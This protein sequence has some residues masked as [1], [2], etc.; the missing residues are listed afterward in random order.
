M[1][2]EER[3]MIESL[4]TRLHEAGT[5]I[6]KDQEAAALIEEKISSQKDAVYQLT[7]ATLLQE[8]ALG[9]AQ[10]QIAQL[11][12][13]LAEQHQQATEQ[14][15]SGSFLGNLFGGSKQQAA[16]PSAAGFAAGKN[17]MPG[18]QQFANNMRSQGGGFMGGGVG[19][20]GAGGSFLR[21]AAAGAVGVAGG[22]F[23]FEGL[24]HLF[25][26]NNTAQ[27]AVPSEVMNETVINEATPTESSAAGPMDVTDQQGSI[28]DTGGFDQGTFDNNSFGD[29][30]D[31]GGADDFGGGDFGGDW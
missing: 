7:Q 4:G 29:F 11:R 20:Q 14:K 17:P 15:P 18:Q 30:S 12:A 1:L 16:P 24:S 5:K 9:Q 22:M 6:E 23:L 26:G 3:Q 28:M 31:F 2:A 19:Q 21:N 13:E 25:G 10:Q 27:A 8:H